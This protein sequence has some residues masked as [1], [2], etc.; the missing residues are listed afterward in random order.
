MDSQTKTAPTKAPREEPPETAH[1]IIPEGSVAEPA[2]EP[3]LPADEVINIETETAEKVSGPQAQMDQ[4]REDMGITENVDP[5]QAL[6]NA[7][8]GPQT[9]TWRCRR[10]GTTFSIRSLDNASYAKAQ[11]QATRYVRNRRTGRME[12][13]VDGATL[14]FLVVVEG[15]TNPSFKDQNVLKKFESI[16]PQDAVKKALLP[17]EI[18]QLAEKILALSG[19]D[20]DVED[21]GKD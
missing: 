7:P 10:L 17:G 21:L 4:L 19:F 14:S 2:A 16:G 18:D 11:E 6:L 8:I 15:V 1:S 13:D 5:L 20:E 12:K 9:G 3:L